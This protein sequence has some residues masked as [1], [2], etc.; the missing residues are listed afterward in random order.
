MFAA[1]CSFKK[2]SMARP[3]VSVRLYWELLELQKE[4][5]CVNSTSHGARPHARTHTHAWRGL[6]PQQQ[7]IMWITG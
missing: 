3:L 5:E 1:S 6:V 7:G 4:V 2:P